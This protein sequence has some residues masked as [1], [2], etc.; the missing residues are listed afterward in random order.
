MS[1]HNHDEIFRRGTNAP[2]SGLVTM[3]GL[4]AVVGLGLFAFLLTGDDPGRAWRMFLINFLFF[5]GIAMG[6]I[7]FVAIHK[8]T[9][10]RW[11]GPILRFAE[12]GVAFLPISLLCFL[13]L[14]LGRDH[15]FPW[16]EHPTP[17]RGQWLT[18]SWVFGRD[19]VC[20][21]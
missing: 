14:F 4:L 13:V 2:A 10:A 1:E 20:V 7:L 11:A 21:Q 9:N 18:T 3:G 16:I 6:G 15:L 5:T 8:V 19:L 17:A 12:A